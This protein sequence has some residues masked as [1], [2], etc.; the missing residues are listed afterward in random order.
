MWSL[1]IF[2]AMAIALILYGKADATRHHS[3]RNEINRRRDKGLLNYSRQD[4]SERK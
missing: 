2:S 1:L 4:E 3:Q